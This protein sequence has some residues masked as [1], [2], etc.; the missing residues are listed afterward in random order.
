MVKFG[1]KRD[2]PRPAARCASQRRAADR[3]AEEV[4]TLKGQLQQARRCAADADLGASA[5]AEQ[6]ERLRSEL[7]ASEAA[8]RAGLSQA[9]LELDA[10]RRAGL[11]ALDDI[12][13]Q[14]EALRDRQWEALLSEERRHAGEEDRLRA[15][16]DHARRSAQAAALQAAAAERRAELADEHARHLLHELGAAEAARGRAE[17]DAE[18]ALLQSAARAHEAEAAA[19]AT[20]KEAERLSSR[21]AAAMHILGRVESGLAGHAGRALALCERLASSCRSLRAQLRGA[22]ARECI[23][24][25]ELAGCRAAAGNNGSD[26]QTGVLIQ[27][28]LMRESE[29]ADER[30]L[31]I[32][33]EC[34]GGAD[35]V[36]VGEADA[37]SEQQ[38]RAQEEE[39]EADGPLA[40]NAPDAPASD[41]SP[42]DACARAVSGGAAAPRRP[43]VALPGLKGSAAPLPSPLGVA[44]ARQ[45]RSARRGCGARRGTSSDD[46]GVSDG[47]A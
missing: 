30:A 17:A 27:A 39:E 42:P 28:G 46:G 19:G 32:A 3:H 35:L 43:G 25:A 36:Q 31:Q 41:V 44:G 20:R 10:A 16:R 29:L 5:T 11:S 26:R 7:S 14:M 18:D 21:A 2:K 34:E 33:A 8:R 24:R 37:E 23:L 15:D 47:G 9:A 1:I 4:Q 12:R 13:L 22:A 40:S 6:V 45:S 38:R